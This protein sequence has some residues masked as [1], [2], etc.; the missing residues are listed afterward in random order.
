MGL[1]PFY[2]CKIRGHFQSKGQGAV[3]VFLSFGKVVRQNSLF[4]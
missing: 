1:T 4:W 2:E 3:I